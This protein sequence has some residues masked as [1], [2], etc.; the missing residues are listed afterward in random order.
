MEAFKMKH[1]IAL[2]AALICA[3][4]LFAGGKKDAQGSEEGLIRIASKPMTEQ[5]ILTE[6]LKQL[7]EANTN[8]KV[9]LTKGIGGGTTNIH[10]ALIKGDFDLYPE[11]TGTAWAFVVKRDDIPKSTE[12]VLSVLQSEYAKLGLEWTELYGF[13]NTFAIVIRNDAADP[14]GVTSLSELALIAPNL[15]FGANPD[16]YEKADGF[17]PLCETYGLSFKKTVDLD[18]GLKY[19]AIEN[20]DVDVINAFTTDAR[21]ASAPV[22]ALTD[23]KGFFLNYYCGTVVRS[24]TLAKYPQL[25]AIL[26]KM[27]NLISNEEMAAMN[28]AVELDHRDE[29]D[30]A[31]EFLAS[32][33]LI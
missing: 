24:D 5:Y 13:E 33:G 19:T 2:A 20:G 22:R 7:I 28:A 31:R 18:M 32:K 1:I 25:R 27:H 4:S 14:A 15:T 23:D 3:A 17:T 10:P 12:E 29:V 21:L 6:I 9:Q 26:S 30:V 11:Y 16:C 8:L